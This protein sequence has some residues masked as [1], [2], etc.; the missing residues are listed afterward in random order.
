MSVIAETHSLRPPTARERTRL[1]LQS[2]KD[3][4]REVTERGISCLLAS[5]EDMMKFCSEMEMAEGDD[6]EEEE[7]NNDGNN[8]DK[9]VKEGTMLSCR[10]ILRGF[11]DNKGAKEFECFLNSRRFEGVTNN[12]RSWM[13]SNKNKST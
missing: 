10:D 4:S 12:E 11:L 5:F 9:R 3:M 2:F 13:L 8:N 6:A 1:L 7:S